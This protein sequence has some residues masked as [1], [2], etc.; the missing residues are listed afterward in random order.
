[1]AILNSRQEFLKTV[2][3]PVVQH[4]KLHAEEKSRNPMCGGGGQGSASA[5]RVKLPALESVCQT[6]AGAYLQDTEQV[7]S[8]S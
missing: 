2:G 8:S 4:R 5:D 6:S 3:T 7:K 1:M